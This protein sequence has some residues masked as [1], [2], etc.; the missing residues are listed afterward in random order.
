MSL[1]LLNWQTAF[2]NFRIGQAA[3]I[4]VVVSIILMVLTLIYMRVTKENES[5]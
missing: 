3:A 2:I 5:N 4:G 1:L